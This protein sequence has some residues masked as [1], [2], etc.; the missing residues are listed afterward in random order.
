MPVQVL[1]AKTES[2]VMTGWV[3]LER[4]AV[5]F[6]WVVWWAGGLSDRNF[7]S[8]DDGCG[9][10]GR[11]GPRRLLALFAFLGLTELVA[12]NVLSIG[13]YALAYRT[14]RQWPPDHGGPDGLEISLHGWVAVRYLGWES[15]FH[16]YLMLVLPVAI[17]SSG[18]HG[19]DAK[20]VRWGW[21]GGSA[22][23]YLAMD[24]FMVTRPR[25]SAAR[26]SDAGAAR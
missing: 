25:A 11:G 16:Y 22:L 21:G 23:L 17:V 10:P 2:I 4:S 14:V 18:L 5:P 19:F 7:H 24:A 1:R 12:L 20:W 9:R 3:A 13:V 6:V 15:G 8:N 26:V